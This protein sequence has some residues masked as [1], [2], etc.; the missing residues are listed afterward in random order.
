MIGFPALRVK[1]LYLALVTLGLAVLFPDLTD[2]FVNGTGGTNLSACAASELSRPTGTSGSPTWL[3]DLL[4]D[5]V[6]APRP[7][8]V[9]PDA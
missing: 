3:A 9:L 4:D 1:G 8:G 2:K 6:G 5:Y 7:V